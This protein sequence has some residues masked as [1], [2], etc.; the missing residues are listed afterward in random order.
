MG[1]THAWQLSLVVTGVVSCSGAHGHAVVPDAAPLV[2]AFVAHPGLGANVDA[3][4]VTFRVWA[5]HATAASVVIG[6]VATAMVPD[7]GGTYSVHV[8]GATSGAR[9]TYRFAT[10]T[11]A[12]DRLDPYGREVTA[13]GTASIVVDPAAYAWQTTSFARPARAD[14]VVYE[15]HVGSFTSDGTLTAA[16]ARLAELAALGIDV[17]ELLPI[18][19][20]GAGPKTWGYNPQLFFAPKAELGSAD[21]VRAFVDEAHRLGIAVWLDVVYNHTDGWDR[22]P[23]RCFDGWCPSG[24][25][26]VY[27]F[28][29][30]TYANT[31]W[32]P[33]PDYTEQRVAQMIY[34]ADDWWLGDMHGDGFRWD[35]VSNIRGLDGQGLTPGG[36]ELLRTANDRAHALGATVVAEDLKGYAAITE[37]TVP[38]RDGFGFDAQWDGW[39]YG[40]DALLANAS[41]DGR[42]LGV[43]AGGLTGGYDGDAFARVLFTEDHDTVGNGGARL[44]SKIDPAQP[45]SLFARR[46]AMLGGVLLLTTPGVPMLFMGQ[47]QLATGSFTSPAVPL[48]AATTA[49][50]KM[51]AFYRD[52]IWLR[53]NRDATSGGLAAPG[54]EILHR[55]D[56]AK[57][58]AYRRYGAPGQDVIVLVNLR[59]QAYARYEI[60]VADPGPWRVRLSTDD[61]K[62]G[63]DFAGAPTAPLVAAA[64]AR[65]G[66]PYTLSIPIGAYGAIVL[67]K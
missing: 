5:P 29:D 46:R 34:D 51:I 52:L 33:R 3:S 10:P 57:V 38:G 37:P 21:D 7:A 12:L 26:G 11:G 32:G 66:K 43:V 63:D 19:S 14:A 55:N 20:F 45:E 42:D 6:G 49:G 1:M 56:A 9:Y 41:D 13:D 31:P 39:G 59:N 30:P 67:T 36:A 25:A 35:S 62:Y 27:F 15:L 53:R 8:T 64:G 16:R 58:I 22:A 4:G 54:V 60:G 48:P 40:I 47:E 18:Q 61:T 50:E 17:V 24:D 2:D 44:P 23:L 65:D 28:A